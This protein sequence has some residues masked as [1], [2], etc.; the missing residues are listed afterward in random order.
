M[1]GMDASASNNLDDYSPSSTVI[2]FD[3][4]I[5]LLR[6][7][8]PAGP[9]DNPSAGPFVLAFR[10]SQAWIS[11]YRACERKIIL[12]CQE[13]A[14]IG[15]AISASSKC[16]PP[17]WTALMGGKPTDLKERE[18]CEE[19]EMESCFAVAKEKCIG[20]ARDKC[21]SPFRDA[22]IAVREK[23]LNSKEA[24]RLIH[25]A[26][27]SEESLQTMGQLGSVCLSRST[28]LGLTNYKASEL[29]GSDENVRC[30]LGEQ[31]Q[32]TKDL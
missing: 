1:L 18:Q 4:P 24:L 13:G 17:W 29:L 9:L 27:L 7:P 3:R 5:P 20:F 15:C 30:I 28:K 10:D 21:L 12:Q 8:L 6:G 2:N 22:R 32:G 14:R 16:K 31:Q 11:S 19:R 26:S 23:G 25:L